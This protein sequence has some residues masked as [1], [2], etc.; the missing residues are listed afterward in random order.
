MCHTIF[1]YSDS[2][3]LCSDSTSQK[4]EELEVV[5]KT[6]KAEDRQLAADSI[7]QAKPQPHLQIAKLLTA[8]KPIMLLLTQPK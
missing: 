6:L 3:R 1:F 4:C 7:S 5:V 2:S 8:T